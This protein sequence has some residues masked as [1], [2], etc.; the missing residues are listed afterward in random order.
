MSL[1][2]GNSYVTQ[3]IWYLEF[4]DLVFYLIFVEH[5]GNDILEMLLMITW[6]MWFNRNVVRHNH[7][8]QSGKEV[9]QLARFLLNEF[10]TGNHTISQVKD[11][12]NDPRTLPLAPN[13]KVSVD[14]AVFAQSQ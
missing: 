1:L 11:N 8:R 9:V 14:G 12:S 10:Q 3:G 2:S 5:V 13:Y 7:F 6:L 4:M